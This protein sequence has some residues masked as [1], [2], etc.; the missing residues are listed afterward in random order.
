[1]AKKGGCRLESRLALFPA[2][3]SR[4]G[5]CRRFASSV[6][7]LANTDQGPT[8]GK[9]H[10]DAWAHIFQE[11]SLHPG[12]GRKTYKSMNVQSSENKLQRDTT[13]RFGAQNSEEPV[14][15]S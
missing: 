8:R 14:Q 2:S 7:S 4:D 3:F 10:K 1:M 11:K 6:Y 15:W 5:L 13:K 9:G 12:R